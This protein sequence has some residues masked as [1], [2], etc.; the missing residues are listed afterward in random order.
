MPRFLSI[1]ALATLLAGPALADS[2][3]VQPSPASFDDT[4]FAV[5]SAILGQGLVIDFVSHVGDM[6]ER[7]R[8]DVGSDRVLFQGANIYLF[9]SASVSR[10]VIEADP[11]NLGHC[12]YGIHVFRNNEGVHIGYMQ[13][14]SATMEPVNALMARIVA[15]ALN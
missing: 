7:T 12:P 10:H 13:H 1:A 5:E 8:A 4:A 15:E 3:V 6:L 2:F 9:C 14:D 11:A